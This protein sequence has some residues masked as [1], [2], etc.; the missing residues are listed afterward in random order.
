MG[1]WGV[2]GR[3]KAGRQGG[4]GQGGGK[5]GVRGPLRWGMKGRR[6]RWPCVHGVGRGRRWKGGRGQVSGWG[7]GAAQLRGKCAFAR[8]R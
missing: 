4:K 7:Q 6:H 3:G 5:G 1:V 8:R 2:L